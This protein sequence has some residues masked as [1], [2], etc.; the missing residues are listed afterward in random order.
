MR[1]DVKVERAPRYVWAPYRYEVSRQKFPS[2]PVKPHGQ[3]MRRPTATAPL[4]FPHAPHNHTSTSTQ[5]APRCAVS[6]LAAPPI[7]PSP[8]ACALRQSARRLPT[9][10]YAPKP[11]L[12][13][14]PCTALPLYC[15]TPRTPQRIARRRDPLAYSFECRHT[16]M[17]SFLALS[18]ATFLEHPIS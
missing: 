6:A 18:T 11:C 10:R 5:P 8:A 1:K 16:T 17:S 12:R 14:E 2:A 7:R 13:A 9:P 3:R 15:C 4:H